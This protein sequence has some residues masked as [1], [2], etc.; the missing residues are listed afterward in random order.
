MNIRTALMLAGMQIVVALL[1][2]A[3]RQLGYWDQDVTVRITMVAIGVMLLFNANFISKAVLRSARVI[4][5]H[6]FLGWSMALGALT[7]NVVW[8]FA[9]MDIAKVAAPVAVALGLLAGVAYGL[10]A[11]P[12]AAA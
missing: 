7:W 6:R 9:P 1:A 3:G 4:A 5:A 2:A 11:R 8:L 12:E 10:L